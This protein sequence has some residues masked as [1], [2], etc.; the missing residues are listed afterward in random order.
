MSAWRRPRGSG[1]ARARGFT[2]LEVLMAL[3][4]L[5]LLL[6]LAW[7]SLRTAIK[8]SSSGEALIARSEQARTVQGFLRR[9]LAQAMPVAYERLE[10]AGAELRFE[11][12][13]EGLRFV[14]P[15]PGYLSRGGAHVQT[16]SLVGSGRGLRLEFN[17]EQLNGYD[18]LDPAPERDPVV[19]VEGVAGGRFE[20]RDLDE[21]GRLS[22][23]TSDWDNPERLPLMVR[24]A[25]DFERD[26]PRRWPEFEVALLAAAA[27]VQPVGMGQGR[28][29][30][31]NDPRRPPR[32][33]RGER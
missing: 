5:A 18:P 29:R 19:L 7:G 23:W 17:H 22:D 11:G 20:F 2:L 31:I 14:A 1:S 15:M 28:I 26:D 10:D 8:A 3:V 12:S 9:Q 4:L 30:G 21:E 25:L 16:L 13:A 32:P 24:L 33:R 27:G 6:G